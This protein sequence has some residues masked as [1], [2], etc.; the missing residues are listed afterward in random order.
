M[1]GGP[2]GL[3]ERVRATVRGVIVTVVPA[4]VGR[5]VPKARIEAPQFDPASYCLASAGRHRRREGV[6]L[7]SDAGEQLLRAL[8]VKGDAAELRSA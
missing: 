1:A 6:G 4:D 2:A 3:R 5:I 8:G 7:C